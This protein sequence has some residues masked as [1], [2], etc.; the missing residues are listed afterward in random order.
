MMVSFVAYLI[1]MLFTMVV[2]VSVVL[3]EIG[4]HAFAL[5]IAFIWLFEL[6]EISGAVLEAWYLVLVAAIGVSALYVFVKSVPR[7]YSEVAGRGEPRNHSALFDI[8]GLMFA[9]FFVNAAIVLF[10]TLS[11]SEPTAPSEGA[12]DWEMLFL[13]ANASVWE[14]II[15]RVL[16][17]GVPLI[18][19]S[20][21]R[22]DEA[23]RPHRL[24]LGGGIEIRSP[25][26]ALILLSAAIFG[27]AHYWSWGLWKVFPSG[28]AGIA[29][30]YVFLRHGLAASIL[31]HFSFDYLSMPILIFDPSAG[32]QIGFAIAIILW[33]ALGAVFTVY[34][35]IRVAEFVMRTT[36]LDDPVDRAILQRL[37]TAPSGA[38]GAH[39]WTERGGAGSAYMEDARRREPARAPPGGAWF[40][41]PFCG[42]AEARWQNGKLQC[43]GC[44]RLFE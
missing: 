10:L 12:E 36:F 30:G 35:A 11:G 44:G 15:I 14:E 40:A 7:F 38:Q 23:A 9:V 26:A 42:S 1:I 22:Q 43:L 6:G 2:G 4:G 29:F 27:I 41:C 18:I 31:L 32:A 39:G 24:L 19:I 13:L 3:P 25:E 20:T 16:L 21:L 33:V 5:Q 28:L 34:F 17:I 37:Q 8:S